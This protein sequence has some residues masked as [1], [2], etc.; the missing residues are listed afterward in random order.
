MIREPPPPLCRPLPRAPSHFEELTISYYP[1]QS[2]NATATPTTLEN[3]PEKIFETFKV[4]SIQH[5]S[6]TYATVIAVSNHG[7]RS[8]REVRIWNGETSVL[9]SDGS[10]QPIC[11]GDTECSSTKVASGTD[12]NALESKALDALMAGKFITD[13][14][15]K[16]YFTHKKELAAPTEDAK[17]MRRLLKGHR[18]GGGGRRLFADYGCCSMR[19]G[20]LLGGDDTANC[21]VKRKK[22][23]GVNHEFHKPGKNDNG[24]SK[25]CASHDTCL[26]GTCKGKDCNCWE[27]CD[28][29][30]AHDVQETECGFMDCWCGIVKWSIEKTMKKRPNKC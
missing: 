8:A 15:V 1:E 17:K 10:T 19:L 23:V 22:G 11:G 7:A 29:Q 9:L 21:G 16:D 3:L 14:D 18:A 6:D 4:A 2:N 27:Q 24:P 12:V 13:D 5:V 30:L 28:L 26:E 25:A 20:F